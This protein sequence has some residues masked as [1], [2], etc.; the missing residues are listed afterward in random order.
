MKSGR[1]F[2]QAQFW[3]ARE[4]RFVYLFASGASERSRVAMLSFFAQPALKDFF[5]GDDSPCRVSND[6]AGAFFL[7][8]EQING[9]PKKKR[10]SLP[11]RTD[12][13]PRQE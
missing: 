4:N 1:I 10:D 8:H 11:D 7:K 6:T 12:R 9:A 2:Q 5:M 3:I 13:K